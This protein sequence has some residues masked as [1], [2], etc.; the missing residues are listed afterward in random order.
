MICF[1]EIP[2]A[3]ESAR[4]LPTTFPPLSP[5]PLCSAYRSLALLLSFSSA[6]PL[7][8]AN[9]V[10]DGRPAP[11]AR[12]RDGRYGR[13]LPPIAPARSRYFLPP[14]EGPT[15]EGPRFCDA[16]STPLSPSPAATPDTSLR[17]FY[18]NPCPTIGIADALREK[19]API[20]ENA[21]R[22]AISIPTLHVVVLR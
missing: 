19:S 21:P 7:Y 11:Y 9:S 16:R 14:L 1:L 8:A 5:A 10:H 2:F 22:D 6:S 15:T 20:P 13:A 17:I 18:L 4:S 3:Q 12:D